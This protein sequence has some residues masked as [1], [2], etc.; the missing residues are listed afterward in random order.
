MGRIDRG[1]GDGGEPARGPPIFRQSSVLSI[2]RWGR[3]ICL[4]AG[5]NA[6]IGVSRPFGLVAEYGLQASI[7]GNLRSPY[8]GPHQ[9]GSPLGRDRSMTWNATTGRL[10]VINR[11]AARPMHSAAEAA[12]ANAQA[13]LWRRASSAW[14]VHDA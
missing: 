5:T 9:F 14:Y 4:A 6:S 11:V 3:A 7:D 1:G 12:A 10:I 2:E 13:A 8:L